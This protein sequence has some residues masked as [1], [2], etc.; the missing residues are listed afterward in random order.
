MD[1]SRRSAGKYWNSSGFI[2]LLVA[3]TFRT[4]TAVI[5]A[6]NGAAVSI[7]R[8]LGYAWLLARGIRD[9]QQN[10][11]GWSV[12]YRGVRLMSLSGF[13]RFG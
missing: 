13:G 1:V 11:C 3:G 7:G 6:T 12:P 4:G 2:P 5:I 9:Q 8:L 10:R